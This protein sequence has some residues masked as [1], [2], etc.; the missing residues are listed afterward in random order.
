MDWF[1]MND[2]TVNPVSYKQWLWAIIKKESE[3]LNINNSIIISSVDSTTL[4]G[5]EIKNKLNFEKY[6]STI[7]S[8]YIF[9]SGQYS[10][11]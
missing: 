8:S 1:K 4:L 2:M 3:Y 11:L 9:L 10:L 7:I 5:I 6:V